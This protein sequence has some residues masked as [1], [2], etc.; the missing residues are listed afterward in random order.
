MS[1]RARPRLQGV[2]WGVP[3]EGRALNHHVEWE[4]GCEG[5]TWVISFPRRHRGQRRE[6]DLYLHFKRTERR[7]DPLGSVTHLCSSS[8]LYCTMLPDLPRPHPR[9]WTHVCTQ[10]CPCARTH[11]PAV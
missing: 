8:G 6:R 4:R 10:E 9:A 11:I 1:S 2:L 5:L 3:Q 7:G